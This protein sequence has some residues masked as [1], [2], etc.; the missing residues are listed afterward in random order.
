[1]RF[2]TVPLGEAEGAILVHS[3]RAAG[4]LYK[5]G[6]I[7]SRADVAQ[8]K[9]AEVSVV[10]IARLEAGDVAEDIAASEVARA[11]AGDHIRLGAA[12]TGRV[13]LYAQQAGLVLLDREGGCAQSDRRIGDGC[14][15]RTVCDGCAQ[16]DGRHGQDHPVRGA[17]SGGEQ[18]SLYGEERT[19]PRRTV[20]PDEGRS[21]LHRIA[22]TESVAARQEPLGAGSAALAAERQA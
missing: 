15:A 1:M 2:G 19:H 7:L 6:R 14:D 22:G 16:R 13:N 12:F 18:S 4:R 9:E 8:L 11:L 17:R 3:V 21:H 10:T 5:K 20:Q